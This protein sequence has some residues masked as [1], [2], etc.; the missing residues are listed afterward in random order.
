MV[1]AVQQQVYA[2]KEYVNDEYDIKFQYPDEWHI[3]DREEVIEI[4]S[5]I[6]IIL[7]ALRTEQKEGEYIIEEPAIFIYLYRYIQI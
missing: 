4:G 6:T 2:L 7:I 5:D 1:I 3:I